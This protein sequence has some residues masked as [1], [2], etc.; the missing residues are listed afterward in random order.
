MLKWVKN[1]SLRPPN[2]IKVHCRIFICDAIW[3]I[4]WKSNMWHFQFS[5]WLK[6]SLGEV[7]FAE[8]PHLNRNSGSKVIYSNWK[9]L[10]TIENET[11]TFLFLTVSHNQCW[12]L[13]TDPT[14]SQHIYFFLDGD[15]LRSQTY[16]KLDMKAVWFTPVITNVSKT[17]T[18]K[19]ARTLLAVRLIWDKL[20]LILVIFS[21]THAT[22]VK[23]EIIDA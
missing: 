17:I 2:Q 19:A 9:I 1:S 20:P 4:S 22:N 15:K 13:P 5:I 21:N 18:T 11:T 10:K 3:G 8:N 6:S 16:K 23:Y 14:G 7:Y 12:W